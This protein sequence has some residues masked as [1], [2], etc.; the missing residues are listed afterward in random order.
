MK[1]NERTKLLHRI[2]VIS[3]SLMIF[4]CAGMYYHF[5]TDYSQEQTI[6]DDLNFQVD[7]FWPRVQA[8]V[9]EPF[10]SQEDRLMAAQAELEAQ[11]SSFP[12]KMDSTE[13][14]QILLSIALEHEID[15]DLQTELATLESGDIYNYDVFTANVKTSGSFAD[16]QA[17]ISHLEDGP[18]ETLALEDVNLSASGKSWKASFDLTIYTQVPAVN[19]TYGQI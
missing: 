1:K 10:P 4:A 13:L 7:K 8:G 16:L 9:P 19:E 12:T 15:L 2:M 3:L 5:W 6:Q 11:N 18:I 17:F 14:M